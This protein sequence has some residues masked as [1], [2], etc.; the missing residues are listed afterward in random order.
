MK[1]KITVAHGPHSAP[2]SNCN[3][4]WMALAH[5]LFHGLPPSQ[6]RGTRPWP[7]FTQI[8]PGNTA[9]RSPAGEGKHRAW[10]RQDASTG[11]RP[12]PGSRRDRPPAS[13]LLPLLTSTQQQQ[14]QA[15]RDPIQTL[16]EELKA[17]A[18]RWI[19]F[20]FALALHTCRSVLVWVFP[21]FTASVP[22]LCSSAAS[23]ARS[24]SPPISSG[25][26]QL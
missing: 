10:W 22:L 2:A 24:K 23:H 16:L 12:Y 18:V 20:F 26:G 7:Q 1:K 6:R 11:A 9:P 4:F 5:F 14:S 15:P 17:A 21:A 3:R 25:A 8:H 13:P 19:F